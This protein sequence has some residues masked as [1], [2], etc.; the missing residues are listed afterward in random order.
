[1]VSFRALDR[2]V[3][4]D[5]WH[6]RGQV[7]AIALVIASGTAVLVMSRS[8]QDGLRETADAYAERTGF[9]DVFASLKRAPIGLAQDLAAIPGVQTVQTRIARA[10]VLDVPGFEQPVVGRIVSVPS[11]GRPILNRL[12]L[13]RGTWIDRAR[14]QEVLLN[15]PFA[16]AHGLEPG[17]TIAAVLNGK[18]RELRVVGVVLSPEYVYSL[19]PGALMAD[20]LRYGVL[21][22]GHG[23][24]EAAFDLQGAFDDV[25]LALERG[26]PAEDVI[27]RLDRLLEPY[28]GT[29]AIARRDQLSNWFVENEIEQLGTMA[30]ILPT[31]FLAVSALLTNALMSRLIAMER[32]QIGLLKAFGYSNAAVG[33]HYT[34]AAGAVALLGVGIGCLA[35]AWVGR[36]NTE[37]YAEAFRFPLLV[38]RPSA[39][40]FVVAGALALAAALLGAA[41]SVKRATS[42]PPA[43]AML[44]PRP[45]S[46]RKSRFAENAASRWLDQ[47]TRIVLRQIGR[48]PLRSGLTVVGV[49]CAMSLL[50]MALQWFDVI[51]HL[52][53]LYFYDAQRQD[54]TV[55]LAEPES[56]TVL[57]SIERLPSVQVVEPARTVGAD[58]S[59][60]TVT[61]RGGITGVPAGATLNPIFDERTRR[62]LNPPP[63]GLVLGTHLAEKLGVGVGNRVHVQVL[64]GRRPEAELTVAGTSE[65]SIGL[66]AYM[67]L[68]ALGRLLREPERVQQVHLLVDEANS[69]QL[70]RAL[71]ELPKASGVLLRDVARQSFRDSIGEHLN[72]SVTMFSLFACILGF[73][74]TYNSARIALSERGRDLATLRVLGFSSG[75]VE[76]ILLAEVGVLFVLGLPL[77]CVF[78]RG[79]VGVMASA[80]DTELFRLPLLI[81]PSTYGVAALVLSAAAVLSALVMRRRVRRLDLIEVLKTR[82]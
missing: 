51:E 21:W 14:P 9:G 41:V 28:G 59:A 54:V 81:D 74:V 50:I 13:R 1:M 63:A 72:V 36:W 12:V 5:L 30:R 24:M 52:E 76:Y 35:G 10:A 26:A 40:S 15:E 17:D 75:E 53:R 3:L 55:S 7:L 8:T 11:H 29:G 67:R 38:Y 45:P 69:P 34:K 82:E 73:G 33:L 19:G 32:S 64:E 46:F 37:L 16:D 20:D 31:L 77:G 66:P 18:R 61:H 44:P 6:L 43:Q 79:L 49:A 39:S 68:D 58:F 70:L 62:V 56:R 71:K 80:F 2:K 60:G 78:G 22:L 25:S 27:P 48:S 4:R 47:P 65:T 42:L 23:V 57:R